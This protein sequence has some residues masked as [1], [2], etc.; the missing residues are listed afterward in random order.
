MSEKMQN[1]I[2]E[3]VTKLTPTL[4]VAGAILNRHE[5]ASLVRMAVTQGTLIGYVHAQEFTQQRM[6]RK[7]DEKQHEIDCLRYELKQ[8]QTDLIAEQSK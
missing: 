7:L 6:Q 4:Q 2:D 8:I 1:E 3:L 5:W